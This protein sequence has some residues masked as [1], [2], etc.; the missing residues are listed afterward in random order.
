MD[1]VLAELDAWL[2]GAATA[3]WRVESRSD[4]WPLDDDA[5]A[6]VQRA[7]DEIAALRART[8][9]IEDARMGMEAARIDALEEAARLVEYQV[10]SPMYSELWAKRI[11]ALK[12]RQP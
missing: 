6:I 7:R 5:R 9:S 4:V 12:D 8:V 3:E 1:D 11:R 2:K 10:G